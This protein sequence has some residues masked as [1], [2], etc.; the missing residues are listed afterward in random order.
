M[1]KIWY[2]MGTHLDDPGS[3]KSDGFDLSRY[4]AKNK[5][6]TVR[7]Y[8]RAK[9]AFGGYVRGIWDFIFDENFN[10]KDIKQIE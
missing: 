7:H 1:E 10:L 9:N 5:T 4:D 8:F 3:Y 6:Y 2:Y